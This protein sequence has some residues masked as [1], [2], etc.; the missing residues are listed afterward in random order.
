VYTLVFALIQTDVEK[1]SRSFREK[2]PYK[3][4]SLFML[5]FGM[6]LGG[7]WIALS[8]IFVFT[9]QVHV[10]ISQTDHPTAIVFAIDL[11]LLIPSLIFSG[12]VLWQKKSWGPILSSVVLI[13][14]TAYGLA[15]VTMTF[16]NYQN[17]KVVDPFIPL[18]IL[19]T[20]GCALSLTLLMQKIK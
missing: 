10:S 11:T 16:I 18:W 13:K 12:A 20:I 7:M 2:M 14:A 17:T 15:L 19:L 6:L 4:V 1:F 5:F 8:L 3:L 9:G